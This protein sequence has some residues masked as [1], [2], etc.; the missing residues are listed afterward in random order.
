[1]NRFLSVSVPV[2]IGA[3]ATYIARGCVAGCVREGAKS[4]TVDAV[5]I[6]IFI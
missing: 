5:L 4:S 1:M 3:G 6:V 2:V